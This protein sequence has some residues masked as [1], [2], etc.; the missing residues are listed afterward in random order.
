[1]CWFLK[2]CWRLC[3]LPEL[4]ACRR[5]RVLR[6]WGHRTNGSAVSEHEATG[7]Q[8]PLCVDPRETWN[9][10]VFL[11]GGPEEQGTVS[12]LGPGSWQP[13]SSSFSY[14]SR[15][16][17]SQS[18]RL[19][20]R[21][22]IWRSWG[23]RL[24]HSLVHPAFTA[25]SCA[26]QAWDLRDWWGQMPSLVPGSFC[27]SGA[28]RPLLPSLLLRPTADR[29]VGVLEGPG[30]WCCHFLAVWLLDG[31]MSSQSLWHSAKKAEAHTG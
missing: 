27:P 1:M 23:Q 3:T 12:V 11:Q 15:E 17:G 29:P 4:E 22:A 25:R 9:L 10:Q 28:Q 24:S 19:G 21:S 16:S 31:H 20:V 18:P 14:P 7:P 5:G 13:S 2:P 26:I 8:R 30:S 6:R